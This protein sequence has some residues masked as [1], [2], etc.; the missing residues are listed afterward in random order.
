[1][2]TLTSSD[3]RSSPSKDFSNTASDLSKKVINISIT[4]PK[5]QAK[6]LKNKPEHF[7][8]LISQV[9]AQVDYSRFLLR[10][11][12]KLNDHLRTKD[13]RVL[14]LKQGLLYFLYL[15]LTEIKDLR[16]AKASAI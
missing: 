12:R 13:T 14:E 9:Q 5:A 1:M 15:K 16:F 7:E 3:E 4:S 8:S 11:L 2:H 10:V 6:P